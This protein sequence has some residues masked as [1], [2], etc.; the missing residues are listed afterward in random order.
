[1]ALHFPLKVNGASI[2]GVYIQRQGAVTPGQP[3]EYLVEV[4]YPLGT[5]RRTTVLHN[6]EDGAL[7]L[8]RKALEA[9]E[10]APA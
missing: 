2:G 3:S 10:E 8:I 5:T 6:Y 4:I 7:V 1:M 9:L